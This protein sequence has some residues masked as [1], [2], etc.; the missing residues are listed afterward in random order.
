MEHV[1]AVA[2]PDVIDGSIHAPGANLTTPYAF[3]AGQNTAGFHAYGMIWTPQQVA[4]YVDD[5]THVYATYTA[6]QVAA[7]NGVWPFDNGQANFLILNLA[8]GGNFPGSPDTSTPWP[9][10]MVVRY[11]RIYTA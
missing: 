11:V 7:L 10:Q 3:A 9:S 6:A 4:F 5:P 2:T 1:G 8:V